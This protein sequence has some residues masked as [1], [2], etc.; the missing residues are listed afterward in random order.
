M[1]RDEVFRRLTDDQLV[2]L[3]ELSIN[4]GQTSKELNRSLE[5]P[6]ILS[7]EDEQE[8]IKVLEKIE[9]NKSN[10]YRDIKK[11]LLDMGM[12]YQIERP[13]RRG[14]IKLLYI[15]KFIDNIDT[16][17]RKLTDPDEGRIWHYERIHRQEHANSEW[18][19]TSEKH[20]EVHGIL[21][22][23]IHLYYWCAQ[24]RKEIDAMVKD[25]KLHYDSFCLITQIPPP[26]CVCCREIQR[27]INSEQYFQEIQNILFQQDRYLAL[28]NAQVRHGISNVEEL[29]LV[30]S[31]PTMLR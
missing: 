4:A 22:S 10:F 29:R 23:F 9:K 25:H 31:D 28:I 6:K 21:T 27:R 17:R 8:I 16:I 24:I 12:V 20:A 26:R 13:G 7:T 2:V 11:P 1:F 18:G 30:A 19:E 3:D 15:N 14:N 5:A